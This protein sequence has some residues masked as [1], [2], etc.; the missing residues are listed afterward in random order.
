[1]SE[2]GSLFS[3]CRP[4]VSGVCSDSPWYPVLCTTLYDYLYAHDTVSA[5]F[6]KLVAGQECSM[7]LSCDFKVGFTP[8]LLL[9]LN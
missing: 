4:V 7:E 1:M 3:S 8:K 2:F 5:V 9:I 6:T